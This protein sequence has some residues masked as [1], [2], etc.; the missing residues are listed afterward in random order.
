MPESIKTDDFASATFV[1][2][3]N[4]ALNNGEAPRIVSQP[5]SIEMG[6][7]ARVSYVSEVTDVIR[8][9][10]SGGV[11]RIQFNFDTVNSWQGAST[12]CLAQ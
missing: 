9:S 6:E 5:E 2:A 8:S 11:P 4:G 10:C 1:S 12:N 3:L 7:L